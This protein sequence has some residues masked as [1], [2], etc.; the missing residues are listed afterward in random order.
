MGS[1]E[2]N[3][4]CLDH[5]TQDKSMLGNMP[6]KRASG[7]PC[8]RGPPRIMYILGWNCYGL[9]TPWA[10]QFLKESILQK[11]PK[12]VF[13]SETLCKKDRT[14]KLDDLLGFEGICTVVVQGHSGGLVLY[15]RNKD[16]VKI[17]SYSKHHIDAIVE[18]QGEHKFR[19]TGIYGEPDRVK[20]KETWDLIRTLR[21]QSYLPWCLIGD[22][23]NVVRQEDKRAGRLYPTWLI[24]DFRKV[25]E[26]CDLNDMDIEGYPYTWERGKV[27]KIG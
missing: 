17:Q 18:V 16:K 8:K 4:M 1:E 25:L 19:L 13:L 23:N 7:G 3:I 24:E 12:I 2:K 27:Q 11:Q 14:E 22:M 5:D 20:R 9:G 26:D 21:N 10:F 15:R 6:K